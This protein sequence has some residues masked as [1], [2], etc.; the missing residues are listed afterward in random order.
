[1][2]PERSASCVTWRSRGDPPPRGDSS[3]AVNPRERTILARWF[4]AAACLGMPSS[5]SGEPVSWKRRTTRPASRQSD[6]MN[7][8][9]EGFAYRSFS[10]CCWRRVDLEESWNVNRKM[11]KLYTP[12]DEWL[13]V[14]D[15]GLIE[16]SRRIFISSFR[17]YIN[18]IFCILF[19]ARRFLFSSSLFLFINKW[20][21]NEIL[22]KRL[23]CD[24]F[25]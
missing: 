10:R 12:M 24:V 23:I 1:M 21:V 5:N 15:S 2:Q 8:F 6:R 22:I 20:N 25:A 16:L 7:I 9:F 4:V 14:E 3:D 11:K 19:F 17:S 18:M 13:F